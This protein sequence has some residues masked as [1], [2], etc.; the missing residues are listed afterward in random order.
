VKVLHPHLAADASFVAS[1]G[2]NRRQVSKNSSNN[3]L[4]RLPDGLAG[5]A[6]SSSTRPISFQDAMTW[7]IE[8]RSAVQ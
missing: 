4:T 5:P 2:A 8:S 6:F 7:V 1:G 3:V